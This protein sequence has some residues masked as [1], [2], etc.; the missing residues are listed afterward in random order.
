MYRTVN[1]LL[2]GEKMSESF[3]DHWAVPEIAYYMILTGEST[4]EL[5]SMLDKVGDFYQKQQRNSVN[6]IKTFIEP[7][8][9]VFLAVAVGFIVVSVI[10]PMFGIYN[11]IS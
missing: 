10:I 3:K 7:V 5:S 6:M 1:N 8:L 2:K 9:I 4:G 11:T